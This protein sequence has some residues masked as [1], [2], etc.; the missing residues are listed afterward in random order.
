MRNHCCFLSER[1]SFV[2]HLDHV[3]H[4]LAMPPLAHAR[5]ELE[6]AAGIGRGDDVGL[7]Q[8]HVGHFLSQNIHRETGVQ[9]VVN[10]GAA[11]ANIGKRHLAELESRNGAQQLPRSIADLLAVREMARILI[12]H[13]RVDGRHFAVQFDRSRG[14]R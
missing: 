9:H 3:H 13:G 8:I 6:H 2:E 4:A 5:L 7:R 10:A 1:V 14:I 11:A 12:S